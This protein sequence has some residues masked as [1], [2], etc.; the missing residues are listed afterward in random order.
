MRS[1]HFEGYLELIFYRN[2]PNK[3]LISW[4]K[5]ESKEIDIAHFSLNSA[6]F[7]IFTQF[8][9]YLI[10]FEICNYKICLKTPFYNETLA[11]KL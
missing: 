7:P 1:K 2:Y 10:A 3:L 8:V 11:H 5:S 9:E 6:F 4:L